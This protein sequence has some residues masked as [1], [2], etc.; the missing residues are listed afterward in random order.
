MVSC[1]VLLQPY[2]FARRSKPVVLCQSSHLPKALEDALLNHLATD[3]L[4]L[5]TVK[6]IIPILLLAHEFAN[7]D[8]YSWG[9]EG[10]KKAQLGECML[11]LR[12]SWTPGLRPVI[13]SL[14]SVYFTSY[15]KTALK[16]V[17]ADPVD[18]CGS[19]I[20]TRIQHN[21]YAL[22]RYCGVKPSLK[23]RPHDSSLIFRLS[24]I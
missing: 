20:L 3:V 9:D 11:N 14:D 12:Q 2:S 15:T 4:I 19:T 7:L 21:P 10:M 6:Y 22:P 1:R 24:G 8:G 16:S 5:F 23:R 13:A 18:G 17:R